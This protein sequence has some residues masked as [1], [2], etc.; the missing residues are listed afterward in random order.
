MLL[1][2]VVW[3]ARCGAR[4]GYWSLEYMVLVVVVVVVV[5]SSISSISNSTSNS[6]LQQ[7][8][9]DSCSSYECITMHYPEDIPFLFPSTVETICFC[10][11]V[12]PLEKERESSLARVRGRERGKR[13]RERETLTHCRD[14]GPRSESSAG[15]VIGVTRSCRRHSCLRPRDPPWKSTDG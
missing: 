3:P 11:T 9:L 7:Q 2:T 4:H 8:H 5:I 1:P 6:T 10:R 15:V 13:E 14:N 12:A